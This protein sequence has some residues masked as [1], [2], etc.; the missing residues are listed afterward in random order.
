M[1]PVMLPITSSR[2]ASSGSKRVKIR[3]TPSAMHAITAV[4]PRNRMGNEIQIGRAG[5]PQSPERSPF[6]LRTH[7]TGKIR[8]NNT[9]PARA[10]GANRDMSRSLCARRNPTPTPRKLARSTKL[11]KYAT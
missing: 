6:E 11:V 5:V 2:Y 7:S 8:M 3:A 9:N 10:A 4:T 1:I